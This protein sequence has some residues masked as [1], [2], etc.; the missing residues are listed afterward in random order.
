MSKGVLMSIIIAEKT[1]LPKL[2]QQSWAAPLIL[3][4]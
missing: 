2:S 4:F 1:A 3:E